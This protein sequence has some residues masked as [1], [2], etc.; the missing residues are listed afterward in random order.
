ML[1]TDLPPGSSLPRKSQSKNDST[2]G[3]LDLQEVRA[4]RYVTI[5]THILQGLELCTVRGNRTQQSQQL[6][7]QLQLTAGVR[8]Q[9][10]FQSLLQAA[11]AKW[12][13]M[14]SALLT[15]AKQ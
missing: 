13:V 10:S 6:H 12:P 11:A 7:R 14:P 4:A 15:A 8:L 3:V 1:I 2:S 9:K 5:I